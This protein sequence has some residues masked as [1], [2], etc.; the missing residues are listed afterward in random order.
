MNA[1]VQPLY[2]SLRNELRDNVRYDRVPLETITLEGDECI[3]WL[4]EEDHKDDGITTHLLQAIGDLEGKQLAKA[5]VLLA[6]LMTGAMTADE[7][8]EWR[9]MQRAALIDYCSSWARKVVEEELL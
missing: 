3:R 4:V 2:K 6:K 5:N 9:D 8:M 1:L 7:L